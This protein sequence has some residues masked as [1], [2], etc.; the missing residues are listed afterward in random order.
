MRP[1][2][3]ADA[4]HFCLAVLFRSSGPVGVWG[5]FR[6]R[7]KPEFLP[8]DFLGWL[9]L[10]GVRCSAQCA[11]LGTGEFD[12]QPTVIHQMKGGH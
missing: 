2:P 4:V 7:T 1:I 10:F 8:H 12:S 11:L 5:R 6:V 9:A 3:A